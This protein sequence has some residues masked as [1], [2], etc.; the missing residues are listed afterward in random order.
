MRL[1]CAVAGPED[2]PVLVLV[3]GLVE[4]LRCWERLV[5]LLAARFRIVRV[6]PG[7]NPDRLYQVIATG[8]QLKDPRVDELIGQMKKLPYV[9]NASRA[10]AVN[11]TSRSMLGPPQR[12]EGIAAFG[13]K[14]ALLP[15]GAPK[16]T[17]G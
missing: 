7:F 16:S 17:G 12:G 5:P 15:S 13:L 2:G 1:N 6:D 3:H 14:A 10:Y 9:E 4:S 11:S 8:I